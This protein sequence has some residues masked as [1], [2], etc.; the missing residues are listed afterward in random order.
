MWEKMKAL[1]QHPAAKAIK[2]FC[3]DPVQLYAVFLIMTTMY[4]YHKEFC[5]LYT[6]LTLGISFVLMRFYDFVASRRVIGPATYL[7]YMIAGLYATI[8][9]T[10]L[11]Q[12]NYPLTFFVWFLTPQ[13][14]VDFSLHYT[15]AV[16]M[17]LIG[18]ITSSVYYFAKT[19]YRMVMQLIIMLIPLSLYAKEGLHMP[20]LLVIL[21]LSSF[22]LLM[23]Y[24]RQLRENDHIRLMDGFHSGVSIALYVAAF[25][26]IAA[27]IPKPQFQ[28]DREF[29]DNAMSYSTW[30]DT[31]MNA[32]SMFTESTNNTN[33]VSNNA[34]TLYY[35]QSPEQLRLR[36]Q[37]YTYY[38]ENDSWNVVY[39]YDKPEHSYT[40]PLTYSPHDL[41]QAIVD[42]AGADAA[43]AKRYG[44]TDCAGIKLPPQELKTLF[45][46]SLWYNTPG[47][48]SPTRTAAVASGSYLQIQRSV[49]DTMYT[50]RMPENGARMQFYSESFAYTPEVTSVLQC[51][52]HDNYLSLLQEAE[53]ILRPDNPDAADLL[54]QV[55]TEAAAA[56]TLLHVA[57]E[58]DYHSDVID[59]LA[60]DLTKDLTSDFDKA[61]AI[62]DYFENAG[63]V[64][65]LS[66]RKAAGDNIDT[67]LKS[68]HTGVCYE[69]ATAM[70]LMCRS[71]G[72]PTRYVQGYSLSEPYTS[73]VM[74][75]SNMIPINYLI[76]MR[77]AHAFPEVY[78]S[79]YGWMSVEPTVAAEEAAAETAEN[80]N[81]MR[82]GYI[83][84]LL[85]LLSIGIWFAVPHIREQQFRKKL[86]VMENSAAAA[87]VFLRMRDV[88]HLKESITVLEL[89]QHSAPFFQDAQLFAG[90][91]TLLYDPAR[92]TA[93]TSP[94]LAEAYIR[95]QAQRKAFEKAENQRRKA[96]KQSAPT[97]KEEL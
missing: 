71:L 90:L 14:V 24:C 47:L 34:R 21:L 42:A 86:P 41:T 43:F 40:E 26:V 77:D 48:P 66:Y 73:R 13:S 50:I 56:D 9:V 65:D 85:T 28:A 5:W 78:I 46:S 93:M 11:G 32:I 76:K 2:K 49:T 58:K 16:Y 12:K 6:L 27:I 44:L 29:I 57:N 70:T 39:E 74:V 10:N 7:I 95:W 64:Y 89:Q 22:F 80:L 55:R 96:Q 84:L 25:S 54:A 68:S 60:A 31:L 51:L 38:L 52:H 37:T 4:Y 88:L 67:F 8:M 62:Q 20:A 18:F 87:A 1:S 3:G 61:L 17:L 75:G 69:Y 94:Q 72:L 35:A 36:T 63:F 45:L 91:D 82:W 92:H 79:G 59:T 30:S 23:V 81:V 97:H 83:F 15:I 33:A 19:R 53:T